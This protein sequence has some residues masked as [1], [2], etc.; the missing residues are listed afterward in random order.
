MKKTPTHDWYLGDWLRTMRLS[1]A[2]L[3]ALTGWGKRK[4]SEL[5]SG[6]QRY[7]RDVLNEAA[8]VINVAPFELLLH[9][10]DAMAIRRM[11][12]SALQIAADQHYDFIPAPNEFR[13]TAL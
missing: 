2:R 10:D 7:N 13:K 8:A 9:P 4:T 6:K 1:Q 11:R 12:A 5:V 3:D